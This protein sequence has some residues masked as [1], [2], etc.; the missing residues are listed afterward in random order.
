M[1]SDVNWHLSQKSE[2]LLFDTHKEQD[3]R[4]NET[5]IWRKKHEKAGAAKIDV[6]KIAL[7]N[8]LRQEEAARELEK[9]ARR[10][11]EREREREEREREKVIF[12][13]FIIFF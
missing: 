9:L 5:F 2:M 10:K 11:I 8:K 4:Q 12:N 6:D 1:T 3:D 7:I 13:L